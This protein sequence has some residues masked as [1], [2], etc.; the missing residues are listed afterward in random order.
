MKYKNNFFIYIIIIY[1]SI[2]NSFAK[3]T[4]SVDRTHINQ[5][6]SVVLTVHSDQSNSSALNLNPLL[7]NFEIINSSK[8]SSL[9][10]INGNRSYDE[11]WTIELFAKRT[12][13]VIIPKLSIGNE[14]SN[15]IQLTVHSSDQYTKK[16]NQDYNNDNSIDENNDN[17]LE[18]IKSR[19]ARSWFN[20]SFEYSFKVLFWC[21]S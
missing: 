7:K 16:S 2:N 20:I 14:K 3:L 9:K 21:F 10:I 4:A 12:G 11:Y 6:D 1:L 13:K 17:L 8:S 5:Q 15:I 18:S 19:K